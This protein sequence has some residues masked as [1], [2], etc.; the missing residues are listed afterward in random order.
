MISPLEKTNILIEALPYIKKFYGRTVVIKYGGNAMVNDELRQAVI[1]DAVLMKFVG[2]NPVI[3][4]GG[5][6]EI[7]RMLKRVGKE[8][9]FVNG[10][11]VTDKETM[12]IVEM[13]LAGKINK[14]IVSL[15]NQNGGKAVG[16]SGKDA[17]FIQAKQ[18]LAFI[19]NEHGQRQEVDLGHVGAV[20]AI[21]PEII[22]TVIEKGYIPVVAPIGLGEDGESYNINADTVAGEVAGALAADKLVL[23]TDVEGIMRDSSSAD[24]LIS[25]LAVSQIPALI[26]Q[27]IIGGGMIPK[28]EC[29]ISALAKGVG[30][31]HIIDG[32]LRHSLLLE[33]F[34]DEGIGTMV[35]RDEE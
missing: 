15:I 11:R 10:L 1:V 16:L 12:E 25:S 17:S 13:V 30:R 26:K 34:T 2:M 22:N 31:T 20:A 27:G 8:T 7:N 18:K 5:G 35:V 23:L 6:P 19:E 28:V 4:H 24:T 33:I 9:D 21:N 29:C 32:R 14:E 3:V